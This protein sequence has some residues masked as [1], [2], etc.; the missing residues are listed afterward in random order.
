ME[1]K[2]IQIEGISAQEFIAELQSIRNSIDQLRIALTVKK[3]PVM[4]KDKYI[5]RE[6]AADLFK[7][8]TTTIDNWSKKGLIQKYKI[9]NR[10]LLKTSELNKLINNDCN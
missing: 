10:V 3:S 1:K 8:T 7:V 9:G 2:I 6:K 4:P 5:S